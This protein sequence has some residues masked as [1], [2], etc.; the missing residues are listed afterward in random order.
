MPTQHYTTRKNQWLFTTRHS[1]LKHSIVVCFLG[2]PLNI[3]DAGYRDDL[4]QFNEALTMGVFCSIVVTQLKNNSRKNKTFSFFFPTLH[5]LNYFEEALIVVCISCYISWH[6]WL[7][8]CWHKEPGHQQPIYWPSSHN[9][10]LPVHQGIQVW[11]PWLKVCHFTNKI[12]DPSKD[13]IALSKCFNSLWPSDAIWQHRSGSTLAQVM[14]C[15][16]MA[17]N[18]YL[19]LAWFIISEVLWQSPEGYFTRDTSAISHGN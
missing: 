18:Q 1:Y 10:L 17:P 5:K 6:M 16:L 14:A 8:P 13:K 11:R 12:S 19:N 3:L 9:S 7:M 2:R 4:G 15:F